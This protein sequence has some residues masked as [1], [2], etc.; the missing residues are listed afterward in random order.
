MQPD[1][2]LIRVPE[3]RESRTENGLKKKKKEKLKLWLSN[4]L[5]CA[6]LLMATWMGLEGILLNEISQTEKDKYHMTS[7]ICGI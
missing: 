4:F 6:S 7:F 3:K 1:L 5:L 2:T